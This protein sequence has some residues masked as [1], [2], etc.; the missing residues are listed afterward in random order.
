MISSQ[1][2]ENRLLR[3]EARVAAQALE[4]AQLSQ[5]VP[6][7]LVDDMSRLPSKKAIANAITIRP[8]QT[9]VDPIPEPSKASWWTDKQTRRRVLKLAGAAGA[10]SVAAAIVI[11]KATPAFAAQGWYFQDLRIFDS[12][13]GFGKLQAG[14]AYNIP[15]PGAAANAIFGALT[16]VNFSGY[17]YVQIYTYGVDTPGGNFSNL[18]FGGPGGQAIISAGFA[19]GVNYG[20]IGVYIGYASTDLIIDVNLKSTP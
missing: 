14:T 8:E 20:Y 3:L 1:D 17:G 11:G 19:C 9:G 13:G 4:L 6:P 10:S 15:V 5:P 16:A 12:R 7:E 2:H 18:S